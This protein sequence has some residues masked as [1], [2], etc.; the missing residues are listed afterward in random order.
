MTDM[1]PSIISALSGLGGASI[2]AWAAL[3]GAARTE[4]RKRNLRSQ[5]LCR[6]FIAVINAGNGVGPGELSKRTRAIIERIVS[7]K[8]VGV[9]PQNEDGTPTYKIIQDRFDELGLLPPD[10]AKELISYTLSWEQVINIH[11]KVYDSSTVLSL[12][13]MVGYLDDIDKMTPRL[14]EA[15]RYHAQGRGTLT[16]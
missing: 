11:P 1:A 3:Y 12:H 16:L 4:N 9:L 6:L 10:L 14:L 13:A 8:K 7:G 15:L 2:G 5:D